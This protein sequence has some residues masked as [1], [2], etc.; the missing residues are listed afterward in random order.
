MPRKFLETADAIAMDLGMTRQGV[1][2]IR[3]RHGIKPVTKVG[4]IGL[5]DPDD[6]KGFKSRPKLERTPGRT[7]EEDEVM[8]MGGRWVEQPA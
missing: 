8:A 5:Y 4:R 7:K 6:F 2:Q 1:Y 3:K